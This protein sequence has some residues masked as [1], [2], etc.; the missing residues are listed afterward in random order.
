MLAGS[1]IPSAIAAITPTTQNEA[2]SQ[3]W[4][5]LAGLRLPSWRATWNP[6]ARVIMT[7]VGMMMTI[8]GMKRAENS[9]R[10][11]IERR[12]RIGPMTRP[13]KRSMPVHS[14]P[15]TT[16]LNIRPHFQFPAIDTATK[17]TASATTGSPL[18]GTTWILGRS[19]GGAKCA[20]GATSSSSVIAVPPARSTTGNIASSGRT[21]TASR[22]ANPPWRTATTG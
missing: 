22:R 10:V 11:G 17:T 2:M 1:R 21:M 12:P 9:A 3:A 16:W 13:T 14:P 6:V 20:C 5:G 18:R 7:T 19:V 8:L 15:P 4:F